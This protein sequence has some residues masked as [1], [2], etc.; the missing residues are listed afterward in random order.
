MSPQLD[1][2]HSAPQPCPR[3]C[4]M[5][6]LKMSGAT[7]AWPPC[8]ANPECVRGAVSATH[9]CCTEWN[10]ALACP[11]TEALQGADNP[12]GQASTSCK[13]KIQTQATRCARQLVPQQLSGR[14]AFTRRRAVRARHAKWCRVLARSAKAGQSACLP[15]MERPALLSERM[16]LAKA[17]VGEDA[18][19]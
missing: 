13:L 16:A 17:E 14:S 12:A 8:K 10:R 3:Q 9:M 5:L 18:L 15:A 11:T 7:H 2:T 1:E 4:L 6:C 19:A